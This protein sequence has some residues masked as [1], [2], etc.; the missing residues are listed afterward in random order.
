MPFSCL[1]SS[2]WL[3]KSFCYTLKL[4]INSVH[5]NGNCTLGHAPVKLKASSGAYPGGPCPPITKG[6][7]KKKEEGNGKE[8]EKKKKGKKDKK[9]K[10]NQHDE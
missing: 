5:K 10:I 3:Q 8:K 7:Q 9:K 2:V 4:I 1:L 6:V